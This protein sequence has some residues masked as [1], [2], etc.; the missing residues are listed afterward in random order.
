MKNELNDRV[1]ALIDGLVEAG[2]EV[3][4]QVAA[5]VD[6][7][8]VVDAWAGLADEAT[9]RP[10]NGETLFTSW[11]TTK[12]FVATCLHLL[13]DRGRVDYDAPVATY[14]PEFA[15]NGKETVTVRHALTHSAGLPQMP[16][17][18]TPEMMTDWAAMC[19]AIAA[20]APLWTPGTQTGY[21]AWTFGWIIGEIIGRVDSR[22][23]A[24]FAREE[25]C[26]PLGIEDFYMGIPDSVE[27]RV[28]T[29]REAPPPSVPA[30]APNDLALRAMPPHVTTAQVVNRPD[31]R[32]ACIPGGG[33]I[34][35][36]RAIARHYAM[37]A[38]HG[39][40]DGRRLLS[41]ERVDLIRAPQT[42]ERDVVIGG[43]IRKGLGYFLGGDAE[44]GGSIAMG[45]AGG[46]F[47]HSGNG[48]S[49][50]FADPARKLGF[51]LTKNLMRPGLD[52]DKTA[53]Y[54]V[55]E[56]IRQHLDG[57]R[58]AVAH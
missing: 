4:V 45:R 51:G 3:G 41:A 44:R 32:R 49:L 12:G 19:A 1:Q 7:E 14:W 40:L 27:S 54:L 33:G 56:A 38:G 11:S 30:G 47:G 36:A 48:G 25:L 8:L 16:D 18:V 5:Y 10:V 34:M 15:A 17:G 2:E 31:V 24:R 57:A 29:L 42:E 43:P 23:V 9:A 35:N 53:A 28:A 6:G 39:L 58:T 21:H 50:G 20:H 52:R 22:P 37:L 13:A 55:A 46:E 26:Q